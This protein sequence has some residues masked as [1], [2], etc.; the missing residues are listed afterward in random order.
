MTTNSNKRELPYDFDLVY[1][2]KSMMDIEMIAKGEPHRSDASPSDLVEM[3]QDLKLPVPKCLEGVL[4]MMTIWVESNGTWQSYKPLPEEMHKF[5][6]TRI[7]AFN[8]L[9]EEDK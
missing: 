9:S 8:F 2:I 1:D 6:E 5:R 7:R 3:F 4:P